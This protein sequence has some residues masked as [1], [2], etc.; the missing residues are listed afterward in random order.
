MKSERLWH[1][2]THAVGQM[3]SRFKDSRRAE[4]EGHKD[5]KKY[6][7]K[8]VMHQPVPRD[9]KGRLGP[10]FSNPLFCK[11]LYVNNTE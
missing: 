11:R 6:D 9:F 10:M 8:K 2:W 1:A 3:R 4:P 7:G 5:P